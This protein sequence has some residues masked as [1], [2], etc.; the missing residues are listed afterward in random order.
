[1]EWKNV[2]EAK[3]I[4]WLDR[5][6]KKKRMLIGMNSRWVE[7]RNIQGFEWKKT[8]IREW[9]IKNWFKKHTNKENTNRN[10][11]KNIKKAFHNE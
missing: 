2:Y 7:W 8:T 1:M 9:R 3:I 10:W 6:C 5:K 4:Q 11:K